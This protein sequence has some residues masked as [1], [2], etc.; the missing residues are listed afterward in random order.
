[1]DAPEKITGGQK[2][3]SYTGAQIWNSLSAES[4]QA[5]SLSLFKETFEIIF[6]FLKLDIQGR[7]TM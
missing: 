6:E 3:F 1:M 2:S 7:N 4:K 5:S